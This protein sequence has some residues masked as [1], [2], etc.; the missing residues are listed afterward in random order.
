[1]YS[2]PVNLLP[3]DEQQK[4]RVDALNYYTLMGGI[5][6]VTGALVLAAMLLFF[7]Q[8]YQANLAIVKADKARADGQT[9][10]YLD[11]EKR[12]NELAKQL[13][14]LQRAHAQATHWSS[15]LV[16]LQAVTPESVSIQSM[17]IK[18]AANAGTSQ[19]AKTEVS[20]TADSRRS[21][22]EFQLALA[23]SPYFKNVE[24][25]SSNLTST[26]AVD[27]HVAL[28]VNYDRLNGPAQ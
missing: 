5:V 22:G 15:A 6:T 14:S 13:D 19:G 2:H 7:D 21:L 20:G 27:Y 10:L 16:E 9:A 11:T 4:R 3:A 18:G 23:A 8:I 24:I 1:M 17:D 25:E 12:S 28:E 26:G